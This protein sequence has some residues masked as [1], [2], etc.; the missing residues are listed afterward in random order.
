VADGSFFAEEGD[1]VS[2]ISV[3]NYFHINCYVFHHVFRRSIIVAVV[4]PLLIQVELA[5]AVVTAVGVPM[6]M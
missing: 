5:V 3:K 1:D 6:A 4:T 2:T